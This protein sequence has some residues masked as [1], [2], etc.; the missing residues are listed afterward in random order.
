MTEL[1]VVRWANAGGLSCIINISKK[2]FYRGISGRRDTS[3]GLILWVRQNYYFNDRSGLLRGDSNDNG[4][5]RKAERRRRRCRQVVV[6]RSRHVICAR[7]CHLTPFRVTQLRLCIPARYVRTTTSFFP[8]KPRSITQ[9][10]TIRPEC[11]R[12]PCLR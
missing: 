12:Q 8:P 4:T 11:G 3:Y 7:A 1:T 5:A 2:H 6:V 10:I 9:H